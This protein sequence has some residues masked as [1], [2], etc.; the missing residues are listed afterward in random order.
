MGQALKLESVPLFAGLSDEQL[1]ELR[2][3]SQ[4]L[5]FQRDETIFDQE[6]PARGFY[7]VVSGQVKVFKLS[8]EGKEQILHLFGPGEPIGEVPMFSGGSFP[9]YAQAMERSDLVFFPRDRLLSLFK[10]D[11]SLA[12]NMLAVLSRRLREFTGLI[13]SLSLKDLSHRLAAYIVHLQDTQ[14]AA[15]Q[16]HLDVSK[17]TLAKILG[18][19]QETLSRVFRRMSDAGIIA[20]D[21]RRID[22]LDQAGLEDVAEGLESL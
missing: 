8:A 6:E 20:M 9:A 22:I 17:G 19:S 12:M 3:I 13:E 10:A 18:T 14:Q 1:A 15:E 2:D 16:V 11:P 7:V 5:S 4:K 21:R